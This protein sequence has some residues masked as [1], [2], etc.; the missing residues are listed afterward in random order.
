MKTKSELAGKYE[1]CNL[2]EACWFLTMEIT[3][4]R[5]TRMITIDQSQYIVKILEHFKLGNSHPVSTP[6]KANIK[7]PKLETPEVD[8]HLYQL[9]LGSLMYA[10]TGTRPDIMFTVHHLSQ[11]SITLGTEHLMAMQHV[12]RYLNGT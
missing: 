8:Q 7:L 1:M 11:F 10:V 6:M 9:M 3:H 12:Y 2:G 5:V 4:D